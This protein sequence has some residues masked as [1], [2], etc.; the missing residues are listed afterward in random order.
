MLL[1]YT[2]FSHF[3]LFV[4]LTDIIILMDVKQN[5]MINGFLSRK[6]L[7][8]PI[9]EYL[10]GLKCN[11]HI[12]LATYSDHPDFRYNLG[13]STNLDKLIAASQMVDMDKVSTYPNTSHA[14]E[15]LGD[16]GF[17]FSNNGPASERKIVLL[18]SDANWE[19]ADEIKDEITNLQNK[20]ITVVGIACGT[21]VSVESL[22][23]IQSDPSNLIYITI[24]S[25]TNQYDSLKALAS[26]TAFFSCKDDIFN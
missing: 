14:L 6:A 4:S 19:S 22:T 15:F 21:D 8:R 7:I 5:Q 9:L 13:W 25:K 1:A 11:I 2:L 24:H 16:K 17:T 10:V 20:G 23:S 3:R 12:G 18:L 26:M